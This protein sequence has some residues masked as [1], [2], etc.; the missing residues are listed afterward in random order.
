MY[1]AVKAVSPKNNWQL[2]LTFDT[3]EVRN[4]D[5]SRYLDHGI[6]SRLRN[7]ALWQT[8]KVVHD[9]IEWPGG[10]DLDPEILYQDSTPIVPST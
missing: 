8:A 2:E 7:P 9:S 6:F 5:M 1:P 4:F 3:S 10:I